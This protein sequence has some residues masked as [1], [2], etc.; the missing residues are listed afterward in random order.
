MSSNSSS[1]IPAL[2]ELSDDKLLERLLDLQQRTRGMLMKYQ[3]KP[4]S[5][6]AMARNARR[7]IS[8]TEELSELFELFINLQELGNEA[9]QRKVLDEASMTESGEQSQSAVTA[10]FLRREGRTCLAEP[11]KALTANAP[12]SVRPDGKSLAESAASDEKASRDFF[13]TLNQ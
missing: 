11:G 12:V 7:S 6:S 13:N 5:F 10:S 3:L 1:A 8:N 2:S 4:A 9:K